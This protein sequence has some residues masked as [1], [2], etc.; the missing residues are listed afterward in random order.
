MPFLRRILPLKK[1][2]VFEPVKVHDITNN[3]GLLA[4]DL[5]LSHF[6]DMLSVNWG[7]YM[8]GNE[9]VSNIVSSSTRVI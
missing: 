8:A 9:V 7:Q 3:I 5:D 1:K 2:H 6:E 4:G